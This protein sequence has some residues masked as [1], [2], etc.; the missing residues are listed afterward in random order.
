M[1][2]TAPGTRRRMRWLLPVLFAAIAVGT[3]GALFT[4]RVQAPGEVPPPLVKVRWAASLDPAE[5]AAREA[6]YQLRLD[7]QHS[8]RTWNYLL[9]DTSSG[10]IRA[11]VTDPAAE[12]TDGIDR[13][14]FAVPGRT[15]TVAE[16]IT[17]E[18]PELEESAGPGFEEWRTPRTAWA[19]VLSLV[20]LML[21]GSAGVRAA[22][23]RG[24]PALS[25]TGLGLFRIVLGASLLTLVPYAAELPSGPFPRELHRAADAFADWG[26][27]HWLA[28]NPDAGQA[29][30]L[31]AYTAL[32]LFTAGIL[33][34]VSYVVAVIAITARA[35]G[36]LQHKSA[37]DWGLPIVVLWGLMV[38][39]WGAALTLLPLRGRGDTRERRY[40]FAIWFPGMMIGLAFLAAAYAKLDTSGI[41]W[42]LGGAV[43][44]HFLEDYRQAQ[45]DWGLWVAR[46]PAMAVLFSAGAI[47]IEALFILHAFSAR[48][49][50]RLAFGAAGLTLLGGFYLFQ[51]VFWPLWWTLF[52][53][54][55]PW[56]RLA[57]RL[58]TATVA[59]AQP[60]DGSVSRWRR[61]ELAVVGTVVVIQIF[62]SAR[63]AE[64]EPFVSDFGMYSWSWPSPDAFNEAQARRFRR[65]HFVVPATGED[66]TERLRGVPNAAD[67]LVAVAERALAG[68]PLRPGQREGL[69]S[70]AP[71]YSEHVGAELREL[72]IFVDQPAF[73]WTS[74]AFV[75]QTQR[76]PV[77]RVRFSD[78]AVLTAARD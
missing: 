55:L 2:V 75:E 20:W 45:V 66:V 10:N 28:A 46:Q 72:E 25:A 12:D 13:A 41:Q 67:L 33:P 58:A 36:I 27:V 23:A 40:G 61:P 60:D 4:I 42:V 38:V 59:P 29:V 30:L 31:V 78:G 48:T 76:V 21:L 70:I 49:G 35:F 74:G 44:Y 5:R 51:G 32:L 43:K 6:R 77:A 15:V 24:I 71:A 34:R 53:V 68:E 47:A 17:A 1:T 50:V 56:Q 3:L 8:E 26:W 54:F 14:A 18:Y 57:D 63:R 62:A 64:I 7:S 73:D 11:L 65:F 9:L 69:Q 22:L 19:I 39:P 16:R 37:H 52:L